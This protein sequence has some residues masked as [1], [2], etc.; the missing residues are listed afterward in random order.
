MNNVLRNIVAVIVGLIAGGIVNMGIVTFGPHIIPPPEGVDMTNMESL[1]ASIH[2]LRPQHFIS[3]FLAHAAGTFIGA[4]VASRIAGS[5]KFMIAMGIGLFNLLG[6]ITAA[7][8]IPA[9]VWFILLDL[10]GAY[11]PMAWL[12]WKL[13]GKS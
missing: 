12:G 9:P 10:I 7:F 13:G 2:L 8:L 3:P 5:G 11:I 4:L 1:K 6:G